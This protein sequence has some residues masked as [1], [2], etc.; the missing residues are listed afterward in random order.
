[1]LPV[2]GKLHIFSLLL[3]VGR[4]LPIFSLLLLVGGRFLTF[5]LSLLLG[6]MRHVFGGFRLRHLFGSFGYPNSIFGRSHLSQ[7]HP[8]DII[9]FSVIKDWRGRA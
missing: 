7:K 6:D 4:K 3:L 5:S 1:L 9:E 2:G 8:V